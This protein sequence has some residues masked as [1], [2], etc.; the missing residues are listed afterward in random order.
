MYVCEI[1]VEVVPVEPSLYHL[2]RCRLTRPP[3]RGCILSLCLL[4][5][6]RQS[7]DHATVGNG[8]RGGVGSSHALSPDVYGVP[9]VGHI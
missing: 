6:R 9:V 4:K 2:G 1:V 8:I 5:E 3:S 7:G